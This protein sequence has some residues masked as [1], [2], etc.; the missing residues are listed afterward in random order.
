MSG[1]ALPLSAE[2]VR[3]LESK[4]LIGFAQEHDAKDGKFVRLGELIVIAPDI[5]IADGVLSHPS[6]L[7]S[8]LLDGQ[9]D[10]VDAVWAETKRFEE[11]RIRDRIDF[12]NS[13]DSKLLIDAGSF[14]FNLADD[15]T[16]GTVTFYDR[17]EEFGEGYVAE[18]R[19]TGRIAGAILGQDVAVGAISTSSQRF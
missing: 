9:R 5:D 19:R 17:S 7:Y 3:P 12:L 8:A 6:I 2:V 13:H 1:S 14:T 11:I 4:S 15:A 18:R 16:V 10:L